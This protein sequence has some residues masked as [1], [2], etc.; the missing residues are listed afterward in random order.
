[1]KHTALPTRILAVFTAALLLITS[2]PLAAFADDG[3]LGEQL[4]AVSRPI[5][6]SASLT[7][8]TLQG[9][10]AQTP[11]LLTYSPGGD[12]RPVAAYGNRLYGKS[13]IATIADFVADSGRTVVAAINGDFFSPTTGLPMGIVVTDGVL[14][15]SDAGRSAVGFT[16]EGHALIGA[17]ALT[18][19][20]TGD[21][22]FVPVSHLNKL[23]TAAGGI[24]LLTGDFSAETRCAGEGRNVL[25]RVLEGQPAIG[26]TMTLQVEDIIDTDISMA[27]PE[28]LYVLTVS[29][30]SAAYWQVL[31]LT[32]GME[33]DLVIEAA[34]PAWNNVTQAVGGGDLLLQDGALCSTFDSAI[35][36]ANPRTAVGIKANGD[37]VL[38]TLDG[39]RSGYSTGATLAGLALEMQALG[40][41]DAI[42][43]DG[44]GS[45]GLLARTP[46]E[47]YPTL[48][49]RPSDGSLRTVA[50][51]IL[52]CSNLPATGEA[53]MLHPVP[54]GAV[55]LVGSSIE[56]SAVATDEGYH[57][58]STPSSIS[59]SLLDETAQDG[60]LRLPDTAGEYDVQARSGSI[61][62][63]APITVIDTPDSLF[64]AREGG[65]ALTA[66]TLSEGEAVPLSVSALWHRQEVLLSTDALTFEVRGAAATVDEQGLLTASLSSG[67]TGTLLV[68]AGELTASIPLSTGKAPYSVETFEADGAPWTAAATVTRTT[69][70]DEVRYGLS[71]LRVDYDLT[72]LPPVEEEAQQAAASFTMTPATP[73]ALQ[74]APTSLRL[75]LS[76]DAATLTLHT[77]AGDV[78]LDYPGSSAYEPHV[79]VLPAGAS[80]L[81]GITVTPAQPTGRLLIDQITAGY[82]A[83]QPDTASPVVTAMT[84]EQQLDEQ[85]NATGLLTF[86][87]TAS[88]AAGAPVEQVTLTLDG[89]SQQLSY[90]VDTMT[91]SATIESPGAGEHRLTLVAQDANGNLA[92]GTITLPG[93]QLPN[94]FADLEGHW[95]MDSVA[96]VTARGLFSGETEDDGMTYFRPD[97]SLS[98]AEIAAVL[99][100]LLGV[101]PADYADV[102]LPFE[103]ADALPTWSIPYVRAVYAL[104]LVNGRATGTGAV[105]A[106][107]DPITRAELMTILA[108]TL[109]KGYA[110]GPLPFA[111]ADA[112]PAWA[113]DA[114]SVLT[115]L[116]LLGGYEDG[117]I[118]PNGAIKRSEA[119]KVLAGLY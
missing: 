46:G 99:V 116:G 3:R 57:P 14:R 93:E 11:T 38:Y 7:K 45:T 42:N 118:Q 73:Y 51:A 84:A 49:T 6:Q 18:M 48:M 24:Y 104:G 78:S 53:Q 26:S 92:R 16:E 114:V 60:Y 113:S 63:S 103:D 98:R 13:T 96:Y 74:D 112:V 1:M 20:L 87:A 66:L 37:V 71:A 67:T 89:V 10:Y 69:V 50:N 36:G 32:P 119:A 19:S 65:D 23:R 82:D 25:L 33:L 94:A 115:G 34:D 17:P 52:L 40:C 85:G 44:G 12:T 8:Q 75:W 9:D 70:R 61:S 22:V 108:K 27:I 29:V 5:T 77:N 4:Y 2:L 101:D 41:V 117:T 28:V 31:S 110:A 109:P 56:V 68:T 30:D 64:V 54:Y 83:N 43:L 86:S 81:T 35:A 100:R 15:S 62:G 90:D 72:T 47:T 80:S 39:R 79:A 59:L 107:N 55:A 102:S 95:A 106:A 97:R 91:A 21:G 76:G 88:T 111:D 58:A 105:Y